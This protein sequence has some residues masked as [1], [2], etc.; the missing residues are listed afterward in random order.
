MNKVKIMILA[1]SGYMT[2]AFCMQDYNSDNKQRTPV[3]INFKHDRSTWSTKVFVTDMNDLCFHNI[4]FTTHQITNLEY[5]LSRA[6]AIQFF[7]CV[8]LKDFLF[9]EF[10][11][12]EKAIYVEFI[13]CKGINQKDVR[14]FHERLYNGSKVY[15]ARIDVD[16]NSI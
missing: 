12:L 14:L 10:P 8:M 16:S 6:T 5:V 7:N 4:D 1:L 9:N 13:E 15:C 2:T 11:R 3:T